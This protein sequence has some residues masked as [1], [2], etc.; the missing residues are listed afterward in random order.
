MLP[1]LLRLSVLP[2]AACLLV[3]AGAAH[4][5]RYTLVDL[6]PAKYPSQVNDRGEIAGSGRNDH[7]IVWRDGRWRKLAV[8]ISHAEAINADGDVAGDDG[9]HPVLWQRH[10]PPRT[11]PLPGDAFFGLGFGIN[12]ARAV[13]GVFYDGH[14]IQCFEWTD[15]AGPTALGFIAD[16]DYCEAIAI[17]RHGQITG[18]SST[19]P[20]GPVHAFLF[21]DGRFEDLGVL[22]Q[23]DSSEGLAINRHGDVAGLAS[24]PP[25]D[26]MHH[27]AT[28]WRGGRIVDLDPDSEIDQSF[29]TGINDRGDIVGTITIDDAFTQ[30][31]V[32]FTDAGI[33]RL[34]REVRNLGRWHVIQAQG[35]NQRGDIV[36]VGLGPNGHAHGVLL[37][38]ETAD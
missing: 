23:G 25:L 36:G 9:D 34:D 12:D 21:Q 13:V 22:P 4:A 8:A 16:G 6:G 31:G 20:G 29:A 19:T 28:A 11:L 1:R 10:E 24:V 26:G 27:H 3:V 2:L 15:E 5:N 17:N 38:L 14:A 32:R 30:R 18:E 37:K 7:A 35:V 33:V